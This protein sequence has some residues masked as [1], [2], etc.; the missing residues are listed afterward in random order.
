MPRSTAATTPS[1]T[2]TPAAP[3]ARRGRAARTP[4]ALPPTPLGSLTQPGA[5]TGARCVACG[6]ERVTEVALVLTDGTPVRFTSCYSCEHRS[7]SSADGALGRAEVLDR[8][9]KVG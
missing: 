8:A 6:S 2:T 3:K 5:R 7:W 9:R 1:S 4:R